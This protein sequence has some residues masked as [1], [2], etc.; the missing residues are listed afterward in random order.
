MK[1]FGPEQ[2]PSDPLPPPE[3]RPRFVRIEQSVR[4]SREVWEE[5]GD[6]A[7]ADYLR[8]LQSR[9]PEGC[10]LVEDVD[11]FHDWQLTIKRLGKSVMSFRDPRKIKE[12]IVELRA[13]IAHQEKLAERA[14]A[15]RVNVAKLRRHWTKTNPRR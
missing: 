10:E 3:D 1:G 12:G 8:A 13:M 6:S 14:R 9:L 7:R 5:C 2:Y 15:A 11:R 4:T